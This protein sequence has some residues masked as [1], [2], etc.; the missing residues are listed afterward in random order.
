[1]LRMIKAAIEA[2]LEV[3]AGIPVTSENEDKVDELISLLNEN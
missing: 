1:M 2:G 3:S